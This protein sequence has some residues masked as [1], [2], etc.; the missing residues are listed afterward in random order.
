MQNSEKGAFSLCIIQS[1]EDDEMQTGQLLIDDLLKYKKFQEDFLTLELLVIKSKADL[2]KVLNDLKTKVEEDKWHIIIHFETH[3]NEQGLVLSSGEGV[4]WTELLTHLRPINVLLKHYLVIHMGMCLGAWIISA[5]DLFNR[6]SFK[7]IVASTQ[8]VG[9]RNLLHA[10]T[11][12]YDIYFF[13]LNPLSAVEAM[14]KVGGSE[15]GL[16]HLIIADQLFDRIIDP[17]LDPENFKRIVHQS[18]LI[19]YWPFSEL[20]TI[21][22][23]VFRDEHE[24]K[25]RGDLTGFKNK[26]DYFIMKDLKETNS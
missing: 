19:N 15:G 18:A 4:L 24:K 5:I 21:P 25:I 22:F 1:L 10:F 7:A 16:F 23:E 26:K 8:K 14:N 20:H 11:A 6:A 17:E 13:E 9:D 12:F 2:W 3:G